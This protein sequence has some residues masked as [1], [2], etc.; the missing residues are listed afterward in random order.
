MILVRMDAPEWEL[1]VC[2]LF[3]EAVAGSAWVPCSPS[4]RTIPTI[5]VPGPCVSLLQLSNS[6]A[7]RAYALSKRQGFALVAPLLLGTSIGHVTVAGTMGFCGIPAARVEKRDCATSD[8]TITKPHAVSLCYTRFANTTDG[9]AGVEAIDLNRLTS[10]RESVAFSQDSP[11][12][13]SNA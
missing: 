12:V 8:A 7:R 4:C 6:C 11:Q 5:R 3:G 10:G 9:S 2:E 1:G 13:L